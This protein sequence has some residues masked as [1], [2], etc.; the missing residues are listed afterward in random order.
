MKKNQEVIKEENIYGVYIS[1][2]DRFLHTILTMKRDK[3]GKFRVRF[4]RNKGN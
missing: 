4:E 1:I 2:R 3:N